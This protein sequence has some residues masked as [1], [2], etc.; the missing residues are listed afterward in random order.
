MAMLL[1]VILFTS[2][3]SASRARNFIRYLGRREVGLGQGRALCPQMPQDLTVLP[4]D[5]Q[6]AAQTAPAK[7]ADH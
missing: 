7:S 5:C 1:G 2:C 4:R 6:G 3:S